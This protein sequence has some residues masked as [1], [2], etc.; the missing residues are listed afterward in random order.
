MSDN[1][2]QKATGKR[3]PVWVKA[4][5]SSFRRYGNVSAA[6]AAAG[7]ERSTAYRHKEKDESFADAW[8][9]AENESADRLEMEARRRAERGVLKPVYHKGVRVGYM[10]E[11][12]DTLMA[13]L[14]KAH[15]PEKYRERQDITSDGKP[16]IIGVVKMD[17]DEL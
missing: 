12:S 14:L 15:K 8:K 4:F 3:T 6:C 11:Y 13:I 17:M 7:I 1:G 9:E 16:L 2:Q 10:R 5:L